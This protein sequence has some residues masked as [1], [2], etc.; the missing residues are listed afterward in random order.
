MK[1]STKST[2]KQTLFLL[3]V[4]SPGTGKTTLALQFPKP[5]IFDADGN[6]EGP[7]RHL[8]YPEFLYDSGTV[9]DEGKE[10]TPFNRWNHFTKCITA[11]ASSP[12]VDTIIID[13]LSVIQ[14]FAKDDIKRQ[15]GQNPMAKNAPAVNEQ[16]RGMIPLIQQEWDVYA[17]YF[18]NLVAQ[19]KG[20][21]KNVIFTAHHE[22]RGDDNGTTKEYISLQGRS[23]SQLPGM[24]GDVWQT[25]I[26]SE[27]FG[28]KAIYTRMVRIVPINSLDEKGTKTSLKMPSTFP[29]DYKAIE[30]A[31]GW[32]ETTTV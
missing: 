24:F 26:K 17:F 20:V 21:G 14:E 9:D 4:G 31:L 13:S 19:L 5:Y 18:M 1:T 27:G 15:R 11:A 12:D 16:N 7:K 23:R 28:D 3:L 10:V 8:N 2:T 30:N 29:S 22:A 32:T 6:L 25:Y